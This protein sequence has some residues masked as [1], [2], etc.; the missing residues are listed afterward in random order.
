MARLPTEQG[1][2]AVTGGGNFSARS[3]PGSATARAGSL[4]IARGP[5][6]AHRSLKARCQQ[7]EES[8]LKGRMELQEQMG[9]M[10]SHRK[11]AQDELQDF[12]AMAMDCRRVK[13]AE[14][15]KQE[16]AMKHVVQVPG[17][18]MA[19]TMGASR[20]LA[21]GASSSR[22]VSQRSRALE[23]GASGELLA[24]R[25][26]PLERTHITETVSAITLPEQSLKR[27]EFLFG[28]PVAAAPAPPPPAP[29]EL[30]LRLAASPVLPARPG[31]G[32]SSDWVGLNRS[33]VWYIRPRIQHTEP[34]SV[35]T[36][37]EQVAKRSELLQ[38]RQ[39]S[40]AGR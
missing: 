7:A 6:P 5:P 8:L 20:S 3:N 38:K 19:A 28:G 21:L 22:S 14:K 16:E 25:W 2:N 17:L 29:G 40:T 26:E 18:N 24:A 10:G 35:V 13:Q 36:Q 31:I 12:T 4:V 34:V 9:A 30:T 33:E 1:H 15:A 37:A 39:L 32:P 27:Q 23:D 11:A